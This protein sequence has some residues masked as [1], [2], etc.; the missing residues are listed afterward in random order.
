MPKGFYARIQFLNNQSVGT[1]PNFQQMFSFDPSSYLLGE[2]NDL[3]NIRF[4]IG[5]KELRSWCES[6]CSRN[7]VGAIF[8]I[9]IPSGISANGV[10]VVTLNALPAGSEYDGIYAGEAPQLS[11][12]YAQYDNGAQ[13]FNFYDNFVGNVLKPI[14]IP[15]DGLHPVV[16]NGLDARESGEITA[17]VIPQNGIVLDSYETLTSQYDQGEFIGTNFTKDYSADYS[18]AV[19]A[20]MVNVHDGVSLPFSSGLDHEFKGSFGSTGN[21]EN[22]VN[23]VS[24]PTGTYVVTEELSNG[25]QSF[26]YSYGHFNSSSNSSIKAFEFNQIGL[27][28]GTWAED[29]GYFQWVRTRAYPPNGEMPSSNVLIAGV[30][31]SSPGR[32]NLTRS[33]PIILIPNNTVTCSSGQVLNNYIG[34]CQPTFTLSNSLI[35]NAVDSYLNAVGQGTCPIV[36]VTNSYYW[37]NAVVVA[38][39]DCGT[40]SLFPNPVSLAFNATGNVIYVQR[41]D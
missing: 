36:N 29:T 7:A 3:G 37:A 10:A 12:V 28:V 20:V 1:G 11:N 19:Y 38:T 23:Q 22:L 33:S 5:G 17:N 14:W 31:S 24:P 21:Q 39:A 34:S 32:T 41:V 6:G 40:N 35:F 25:R 18:N 16:S 26:M 4:Y 2:S 15:M 27:R 30:F 8:W 9:D 13:V